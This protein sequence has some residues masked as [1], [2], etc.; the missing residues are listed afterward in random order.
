MV[1]LILDKTMDAYIDC[2]VVKSKEESDHI[3]DLTEVFAILRRHRQRLNATKCAFRVSLGKFLGHLVTRRG[4]EA[5][6]EQITA[7]NNLINPRTMKEIQNMIRMA[8]VL[9]KIISKSSDKC[10]LQK[11]KF[12]KKFQIRRNFTKAVLIFFSNSFAKI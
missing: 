10:C 11:Y 7:I 4:I 8:A 1:E 3:R 12:L 6:S 9:N 5:N 2:M